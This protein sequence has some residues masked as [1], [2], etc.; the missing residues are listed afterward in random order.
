MQ[1]LVKPLARKISQLEVIDIA[2]KIM[3]HRNEIL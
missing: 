3:H 1:Y 2:L